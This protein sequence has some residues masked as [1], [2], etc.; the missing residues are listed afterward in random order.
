MGNLKQ[1]SISKSRS[2]TA[3]LSEAHRML[4]DNIRSIFSRTWIYCLALALVSAAYLSLYIHA[5]LYGSSTWLTVAL[6]AVSLITLCAEIAY[7]ARAMFVVNG[8]PMKWNIKRCTIL[9][10]CYIA[11]CIVMAFVYASV[12]YGVTMAKQP[13]TLYDMMPTF[14]I[15][16]GVSVVI[17]L[18]LLPFIY[19]GM[20]YLVETD[21][22]LEKIIF[23]SY[24]T[25]LRHWGL[26]FTA[27]FLATLCA[28]ICA[29]L[30][31]APMF[32]V[33]AAN[34]LSVYGVNF[35]GDPTGLPSY[36]TVIQFVVYALTFFIW[37]YI[38]MFI[39]FV[40]YFLY[41]SIT[42]REKEKNEM[43]NELKNK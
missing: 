20:K 22:K 11:F 40:C 18:L 29:V 6:C 42:T 35:I 36:F 17:Y 12:F 24:K 25:G 7:Y 4:F 38:N 34:S 3:C 5:M 37:A 14:Y 23:K 43:L 32:I 15:L 21:S 13:A 33:L 31:S 8:Q 2:Y 39:I 30:V 28:I 19:V 26:I 41:G 27:L 1:A 16:G 10:A 9:T